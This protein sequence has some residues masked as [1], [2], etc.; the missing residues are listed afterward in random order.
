MYVV[1]KSYNRKAVRNRVRRRI[2]KKIS[3]TNE[4]PRLCVY[5][6]LNHIYAQIIND[7]SGETLAAASTLDSEVQ[8]EL[9]NGDKNNKEAAKKVGAAIAQRALD[10]GIKEVIFDRSGYKYHG[11]IAALADSAREKGLQF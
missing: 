5:K 9:E 1:F 11:R 6:S 10:K 7:M 2:R 3:G 8:K 4:R